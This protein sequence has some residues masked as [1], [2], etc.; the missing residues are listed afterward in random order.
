MFNNISSLIPNNKIKLYNENLKLFYEKYSETAPEF[1]ERQT[2]TSTNDISDIIKIIK[3]SIDMPVSPRHNVIPEPPS[4]SNL[5]HIDEALLGL[6]KCI[7]YH[8]K[9]INYYNF[10]RI[11]RKKRVTVSLHF[12]NKNFNKIKM[13]LDSL[14]EQ[15][16]TYWLNE[17]ND[18]NNDNK[19]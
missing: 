11:Y 12:I 10:S 7:R 2:T 14:N 3:D 16:S 17:Y 8:Q 9:T 15:E 1:N 13:Y 19:Y 6:D 18:L 5:T 4:Y